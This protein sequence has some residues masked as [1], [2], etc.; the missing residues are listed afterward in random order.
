LFT[1]IVALLV[2]DFVSKCARNSR[3]RSRASLSL[4]APSAADTPVAT[5]DRTEQ[6]KAGDRVYARPDRIRLVH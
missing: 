6:V 4:Q 1:Y 2:L 3:K 5:A